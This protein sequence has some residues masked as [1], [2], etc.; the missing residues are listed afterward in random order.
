MTAPQDGKRPVIV[1][2]AGI[3]G[4]SAAR[5]LHDAGVPVLV[6]EARDRIG[7]RVA[8]A[9]VGGVTL[10]AGAMFIHGVDGNPLA[11]FCD[12]VGI[13]YVPVEYSL[14]MVHDAQTGAAVRSG[15]LTLVRSMRNFD[16]RIE[17]L[18][19]ALP[20]DA[21]VNDGIAAFLERSKRLSETQR[22]HAA[23]ALTHLLIELY[24]SGPPD[25]M[26]LHAYVN[27]PYA[28]FAGGNH[29][30]PGGYMQVVDALSDGLD[31]RLSQP[32]SRITHDATGVTVTTPPGRSSW[33]PRD[34][35]RIRRRPEGRPHRV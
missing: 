23:F 9:D 19:A 16:D 2:G 34:R 35:D 26:S 5:A 21:S 30:V 10:D 11:A 4:L 3:A 25:R 6:V 27:A 12:A 32:V 33:Q 24:E 18:A 29:V 31:I 22:R 8:Q 20:E 17:L 14:P 15:F 28:E 7:G 13:E 1:V